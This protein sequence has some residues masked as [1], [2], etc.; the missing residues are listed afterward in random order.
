MIVY[1]IQMERK[2]IGKV[3]GDVEHFK[4]SAQVRRPVFSPKKN[5]S[6]LAVNRAVGRTLSTTLPV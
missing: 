4:L 5:I 3:R 2:I 1:S 6:L